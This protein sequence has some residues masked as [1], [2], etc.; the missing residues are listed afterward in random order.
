MQAAIEGNDRC[1]E[2]VQMV[3]AKTVEGTFEAPS[4]C[5][6]P[7]SKHRAER[8]RG[9]VLKID[10]DPE[11]RRFI[12]ERMDKM[13]YAALERAIAAAFP[14]DQRVKRSAIHTG[15]QGQRDAL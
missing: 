1:T 2:L 9:R 10:A 15:W 13:T 7:P 3:I 4:T 12:L 14:P 5:D 8:R 6:L 11:L